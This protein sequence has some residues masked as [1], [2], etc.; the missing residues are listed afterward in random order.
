MPTMSTMP[1]VHSL[2]RHIWHLPASGYTVMPWK[3]GGGVTEEIHACRTESGNGDFEWRLS[4]AE[5]KA[6]GPFSPYP[7]YDR[8]IVQLA[9]PPMTLDHGNDVARVLAR[10]EPYAFGGE[11]ATFGRVPGPARDF[12]VMVRRGLWR[13]T[14]EPVRL[15]ANQEAAKPAQGVRAI[16]NAGQSP[17]RVR[18]HAQCPVLVLAP[19]DSALAGEASAPIPIYLAA[20]ADDAEVLLVTLQPAGAK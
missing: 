15:A 2:P 16:F 4:I 18:C 6:D 13:A 20:G 10:L 7:G 1:S 8:V 14:V 17:L 19:G 9:G 12:N 11:A 5:L 3:N